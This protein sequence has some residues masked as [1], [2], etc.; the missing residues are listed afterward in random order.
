MPR[1]ILRLVSG[2]V[3]MLAIIVALLWVTLELAHAVADGADWIWYL[4]LVL[5]LVPVLIFAALAVRS[6]TRGVIV[7]AVAATALLAGVLLTYPDNSVACTPGAGQS[8]GG[9]GI[10]TSGLGDVLV[11]DTG[12]T[13]TTA[14]AGDCP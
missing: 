1:V 3:F 10:D 2:L 11:E 7:L 13:S 12:T 5:T 6:R 14:S 9:S 8:A 4:A